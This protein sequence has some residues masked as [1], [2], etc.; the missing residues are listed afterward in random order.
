[1]KNYLETYNEIPVGNHLL[2][3]GYRLN[4]FTIGIHFSKYAV[5]INLFPFFIGFEFNGVLFDQHLSKIV[6]QR[7]SEYQKIQ[8]N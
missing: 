6:A 8:N 7:F 5:D 1:M 3:F 2:S 4:S